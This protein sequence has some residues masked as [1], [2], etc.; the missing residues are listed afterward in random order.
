MP[1]YKPARLFSFPKY[2]DLSGIEPLSA[3]TW[4]IGRSSLNFYKPYIA[5]LYTGYLEWKRGPMDIIDLLNPVGCIGLFA[6][7]T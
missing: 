6:V 4:N 3:R 7:R 2:F 5:I 1:G